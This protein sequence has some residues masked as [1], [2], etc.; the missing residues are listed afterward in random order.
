[1]NTY[2]FNMRGPVGTVAFYED[3]L[4]SIIWEKDEDGCWVSYDSIPCVS[5]PIDTEVYVYDFRVCGNDLF[6]GGAHVKSIYSTNG[7]WK[8]IEDWKKLLDVPEDMEESRRPHGRMLNESNEKETITFYYTRDYVDAE[9]KK[10][11][12][13]T[14]TLDRL[15][16]AVWRIGKDREDEFIFFTCHTEVLDTDDN[17]MRFEFNG[18]FNTRR[19]VITMGGFIAFPKD[20]VT[21]VHC[22]EYDDKTLIELIGLDKLLKRHFNGEVVYD[23]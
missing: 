15:K 22:E 21:D 8:L 19:D 9:S 14:T 2:V 5:D 23:D 7:M 3:D 17:F 13:F 20:V 1:M 12:V 10:V 6:V 18:D 16:K 4:K 11:P